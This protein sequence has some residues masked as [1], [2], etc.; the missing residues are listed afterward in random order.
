MVW[1]SAHN[2]NRL[3]TLLT[4]AQQEKHGTAFSKQ[5]KEQLGEFMLD[6]VASPNFN[7]LVPTVVG[8]EFARRVGELKSII[9]SLTGGQEIKDEKRIRQLEKDHAIVGNNYAAAVIN[10]DIQQFLGTTTNIVWLSEHTIIKT[11]ARHPEQVGA[12]LFNNISGVIKNAMLIVEEK[13]DFHI[14]FF[15]AGE[16]IYQATIKST[17]DKSE[18]YVVTIFK[19][20]KD[21]I[22]RAK[23]NKKILFEDVD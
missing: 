15:K 10:Q 20:N 6:L 19:T 21:E 18:L 13:K 3:S 9:F 17:Q 22:K 4:L 1:L 11:L 14:S 5:L 2:H 16:T 12:E 23:K 8:D 7:R